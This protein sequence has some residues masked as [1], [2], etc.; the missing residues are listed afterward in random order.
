NVRGGSALSPNA[1]T[2]KKRAQE[3]MINL[4][5]EVGCTTFNK[6]SLLSCLR[7]LPALTLNTAQTKLLTV[8][9][10]FQSWTPIVDG[11]YLQETPL[12]TLSSGRHQKVDLLIG[13]AEEDGLV[14]R[15][16]AIKVGWSQ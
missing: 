3:Q 6:T 14:R 11:I 13:S 7:A 5:E 10:P 15:A 9:G 8:S 12:A 2:S 4:A 16:K 1:V